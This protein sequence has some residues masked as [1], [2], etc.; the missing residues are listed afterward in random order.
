MCPWIISLNIYC[1]IYYGKAMI[2][3]QEQIA[4]KILAHGELINQ[5][6]NS[7]DIHHGQELLRLWVMKIIEDCVNIARSTGV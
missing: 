7:D 3:I 1:W 2:S 6:F 4:Q 5:S